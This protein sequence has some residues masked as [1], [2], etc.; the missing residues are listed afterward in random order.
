MRSGKD[1][2]S[3]PSGLFGR[4]LKRSTLLKG[5]LGVAA[6]GTL[7]GGGA[8]AYAAG[9]EG[10]KKEKAAVTVTKIADL[11]GNDNTI[12]FGVNGTDLGIPVVTPGGRKLYVFG[13]SYEGPKPTPEDAN[14]RSPIGL[15]SSTTDLPSGLVFDAAVGGQVARQFWDYQHNNG[16]FSTV[17]PSDV[18]TIGDTMYLQVMVHAELGNVLRSEI[19]SSKDEGE[20][21]QDTQARWAGDVHGGR[22]QQLTWAL[23]EDEMVYV[24]SSKWDRT[25][26]FILHR[27]HKDAIADTNAYEWWGWDSGSNRWDWGIATPGEVW[28]RPTGEMCLRR[29]EG[30]WVMT[31]FNATQG[32]ESIDALVFDSPTDDLTRAHHAQLIHNT[33]WGQEDDSHVAQLYG[34]Y[35]IPGST[36]NDLHLVVSQWKTDDHSVYRSMQHRVQGLTG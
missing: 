6:G 26:G 14:W 34:G 11:T 20:T 3:G 28:T 4:K 8:L 5:G 29:L 7:L 33:P 18:I 22:M 13:D 24:F 19:W 32:A 1:N 9:N 25:L 15:Y 12:K 31:W 17:L 21:W 27:V 30:S 2:A 23:G 16:E 35:I 10:G 36:I